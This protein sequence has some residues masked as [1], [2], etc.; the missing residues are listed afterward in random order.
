MKTP[1]QAAQRI[2]GERA[3]FYTKSPS[4]KDPQVL[5]RL[6]ELAAPQVDWSGLDVATGSGHTA[7]AFAPYVDDIICIDITS[8]MLAEAEK[9]VRERAI[10]NV[11][12][13]LGDVHALP[14]NE[15][16]FHVVTCRRAAHHF[17]D[18]AMALREMKRVLR[19][20]GR[21]VIDDRSLP[22]D[23]FVDDCMNEID[24][25]HDE[26]HV[27]E[28]RSSEWRRMLESSGFV[29]DSV[30]SYVKHR[31]LTSLTDNVSSKNTQKIMEIV[32]N[33]NED[34]K[35]AM[36]VVKKDGQIYLNHWYIILSAHHQ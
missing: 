25:L 15:G 36:N 19:C 33:L 10:Y 11:R 32:G 4:H 17:S 27:R 34:Q 24:R 2:F 7:F 23:D 5:A 9:L 13:C 18:I 22:E 14:F 30:E 6:I 26:S 35:K 12:F 1:E 16:I 31:S 8:Q 21:L 3:E 29:I 28:Y 20:S